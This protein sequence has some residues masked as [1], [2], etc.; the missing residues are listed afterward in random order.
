ME[1]IIKRKWW[2]T[3]CRVLLFCL[4]CAVILA[5]SSSYTK[6]ISKPW[7]TI[8][9]ASFSI[10]GTF[11]LTLIF[12]HWEK[13]KLS[14]AGVEPGKR[15]ALHFAAG[16]FIGL[17]LVVV[18]ISLL[19]ITGHIKL[20][21]TTG[22]DMG[23]ILISLI[24][25]LLL[26]GREELAFRGYPLQSLSRTVGLLGAQIIVALIF[27]A[28]HIIGGMSWWQALLGTGTGSVLF[29]MAAI[30][31]RG[32]AAPIGLHAAWNFGQWIFGFKDEAGIWHTVVDKGYNSQVE[33]AGMITYLLV[34]GSAIVAFYYYG[35]KQ[36]IIAANR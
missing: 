28:E 23:S 20:L 10:L 11:V 32:L 9:L 31:T 13:L 22:I 24:I 7:S 4:S 5:V 8:T 29:G 14:D 36:K 25:Y 15:S 30:T 17:F 12:A 16:F 26:A 1:E 18:Q 27:V 34:M 35:R 33:I 19:L 2:Y 3:L 6:E 21:R